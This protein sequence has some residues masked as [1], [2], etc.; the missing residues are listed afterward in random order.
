MIP[1]DV[2]VADCMRALDEKNLC[3]VML[4][5]QDYASGS[6][7]DEEKYALYVDLLDRLSMLDARFVTFQDFAYS[8]TVHEGFIDYEP[9]MLDV[10][11]ERFSEP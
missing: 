2:V 11:L 1:N 6:R 3:V 7:I 9:I 4:H 5:P 8:Y 10:P